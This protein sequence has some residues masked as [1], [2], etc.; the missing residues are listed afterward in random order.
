MVRSPGDLTAEVIEARCER[1]AIILHKLG[2]SVETCAAV[3]SLDEHWNGNGLPDHLVA[4]DIS[5]LDRI[6][7]VAQH[8]DLFCTEFGPAREMDILAERSGTW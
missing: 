7:A 6:C 5:L 2:M 8:L 1:G 4:Q 3:Y